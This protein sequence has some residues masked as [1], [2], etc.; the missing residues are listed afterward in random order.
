[1]D[2]KKAY[3]LFNPGRAERRDHTIRFTPVDEH[4][5][6]AKPRYLP[7]EG[8]SALY[9]FG[10]IDAN[11]AFY[12][13]MGQ[14]HIPVHF[15]DYHEHYTGSFS[16]REYLLA[17]KL[18][19]AQA[20]C[21]LKPKRRLHIAQALVDAACFNMLKNLRYYGNRGRDM[22]AII[23]RLEQLRA[24]IPLTHNVP[25]LLGIEG[26]SRQTYY[27]AFGQI[28][29]TFTMEGRSKRPPK[30]EVNALISFGNSMCYT[31]A[32]DAIYHSQ[33]NPTISYLHEPG[34]RRYSLALDIAEVFKPILVDRLIF[35]L[36]NKR[37]LQAS[38]FEDLNGA[39]LLKDK[40]R[41]IFLNA[42]EE[43]LN[44]TIAHRHLDKQVSY[45][46]LV[47]LECYKLVKYILDMENEYEGFKIWW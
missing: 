6:E 21:Y 28:I 30:D 34:A 3:Y 33:L 15:F 10:S 39:F 45:R 38:H 37:E 43:K 41:K 7:V 40:G 47:K 20:Q 46:R 32:L 13:Y 14:Q 31:L 35:R 29:T 9:V 22:E 4:G 16:P 42:W 27:S 19:V 25:E 17:G 5:T 11:S 36:C 18:L 1:M 2:M 8:V 12:N 24:Q 44:E 23:A 26:N